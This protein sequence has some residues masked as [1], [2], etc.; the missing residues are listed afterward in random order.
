MI[1]GILQVVYAQLSQQEMDRFEVK[2]TVVSLRYEF[3]L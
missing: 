2:I 1:Q 3:V